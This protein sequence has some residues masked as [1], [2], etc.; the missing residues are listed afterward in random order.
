MLVYI[1][2]SLGEVRA[3]GWRECYP[4]VFFQLGEEEKL[5]QMGLT[6]QRISVAESLLSGVQEWFDQAVV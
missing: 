5:A 3:E 6:G 1:T 4:L 2:G